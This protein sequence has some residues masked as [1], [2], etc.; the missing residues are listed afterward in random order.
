MSMSRILPPHSPAQPENP[1][2]LAGVLSPSSPAEL[3][4]SP[5]QSRNPA[6]RAAL[7]LG[8]HSAPPAKTKFRLPSTIVPLKRG[9]QVTMKNKFSKTGKDFLITYFNKLEHALC[10][11]SSVAEMPIGDT[12]DTG[13]NRESLVAQFFATHLQKQASVTTG[14][15]LIDSE[16]KF[17]KRKG[18]QVQQVDVLVFNPFTLVAQWFPAGYYP[19]ESCYCAIE[20]KSPS[21]ARKQSEINKATMQVVRMKKLQKDLRPETLHYGFRCKLGK[22][23]ELETRTGSPL[24]GI[25]LWPAIDGNHNQEWIAKLKKAISFATEKYKNE[26]LSIGV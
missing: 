17:F 1:L 10:T 9:E 8:A 14:G 26:V 23:P 22:F 18:R 25:W 7:D 4:V 20:V 16:T 13:E 21:A 12:K 19:V 2:L 11:L 24:A 3:R 15:V 6:V 5:S